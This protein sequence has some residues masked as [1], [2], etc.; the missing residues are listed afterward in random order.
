[1]HYWADLQSVY[2]FRC[3]DNI[4]QMRNVSECLY[5]L[6][7][8]LFLFLVPCVYSSAFGRTLV[9]SYR[10]VSSCRMPIGETA[11]TMG[12]EVYVVS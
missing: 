1:M 12:D 10:I 5:S 8:W 6:C 4:A 9:V 7:A 11:T 3:Y 2:G